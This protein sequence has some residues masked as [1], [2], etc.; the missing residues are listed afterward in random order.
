MPGAARKLDTE[1]GV[2]LDPILNVPVARTGTLDLNYSTNVKVNG[3]DSVRL[4]DKGTILSGPHV[5]STFT[6]VGASGDVIVNGKGKA[7]L[8]DGTVCDIC[9][10]SG[11]ITSGSS[12]VNTN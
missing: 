1:S 9:G 6:V 4:G 11:S 2:C 8:G 10:L 12:N 7:R 5:G 3:R